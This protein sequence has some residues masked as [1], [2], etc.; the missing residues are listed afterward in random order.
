MSDQCIESLPKATHVRKSRSK[1]PSIGSIL[2][3]DTAW[4]AQIQMKGYLGETVFTVVTSGSIAAPFLALSG[5][6]TAPAYQVLAHISHKLGLETLRAKL[7]TYMQ[8]TLLLRD[9]LVPGA[10]IEYGNV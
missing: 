7:P 3:T 10:K 2:P 4:D 5:L 6:L 9:F 8:S 1:H